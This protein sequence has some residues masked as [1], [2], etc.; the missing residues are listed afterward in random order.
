MARGSVQERIEDVTIQLMDGCWVP[1]IAGKQM[2]V[3]GRLRT[4]THLVMELEG[5]PVTE[6]V[7]IS[8]LCG[9]SRCINPAH[10]V[11]E[12][13]K[14]N[15]RRDGRNTRTHCPRGHEFG[16]QGAWYMKKGWRRCGTCHAEREAAHR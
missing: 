12:D 7:E 6:G 9:K 2:S 11:I 8:H 5:R 14:S 15:V 10:I 13:H 3:N 1:D 4:V 16:P